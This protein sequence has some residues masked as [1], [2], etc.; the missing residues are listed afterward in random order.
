S[1]L[2]VNPGGEER[3]IRGASD[4]SDIEF[5]ARHTGGAWGDVNN[6]G[7][8]DFIITTSCGCRYVDLYIQ[9]P[10]GRFELQ[11]FEYG[12]RRVAAGDDAVWVDFDNDGR[13]DLATISDGRLK[14]FRNMFPTGDNYV[15]LD[16]EGSDA[17]GGQ[18]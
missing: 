6:D 2:V 17:I 1:R 8:S 3:M 13:L 12:L 18:V 14:I 16:I 4:F 11:T 7:L 9:Q 5:E 15:E 10:G